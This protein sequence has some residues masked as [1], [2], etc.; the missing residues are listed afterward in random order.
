M[1]FKISVKITNMKILKIVQNKFQKNCFQYIVVKFK[2]FQS[3]ERLTLSI[4]LGD[5]A[6]YI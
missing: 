2:H 1:L 4:N 6:L 3:N 5:Q